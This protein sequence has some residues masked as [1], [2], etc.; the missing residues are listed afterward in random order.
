MSDALRRFLEEELPD[1]ASTL[2]DDDDLLRPGLL[3]SLGIVR[4]VAMLEDEEGIAVGQ[5]EIEPAR[6]RSVRIIR[7]FIASKKGPSA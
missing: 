7:E 4:L 2:G 6:F 5:D 3:D 1:A